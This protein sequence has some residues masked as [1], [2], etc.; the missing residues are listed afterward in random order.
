[1]S[2]L[3]TVISILFGATT[4]AFITSIFGLVSKY[5]KEQTKNKIELETA[6]KPI[7][8]L[9]EKL[10]VANEKIEML[11]KERVEDKKEKENYLIFIEKLQKQIDRQ[12]EIIKSQQEKNKQLKEYISKLENKKA[13]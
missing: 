2:T 1:M 13:A 12:D 7:K 4:I 9:E 6:L 8:T 5:K 3:E 11:Q 10:K